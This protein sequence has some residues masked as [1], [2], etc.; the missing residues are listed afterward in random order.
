MFSAA[1]A[2]AALWIY[3]EDGLTERA[4]LLTDDELREL[5]TIAGRHWRNDHGLPTTT[6]LTLDK[7]SA[8]AAIIYLE[9]APRPL[10]RE[11]RRSSS[12]MPPALRQAPPVPPDTEL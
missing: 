2:A 3:G 6:R 4:L 10:A 5:W 1:Q 11:R 12:A 9:G 7:V 8:F